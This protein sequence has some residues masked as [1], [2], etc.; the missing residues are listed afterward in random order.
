MHVWETPEEL[1]KLQSLLDASYDSGGPH[2]KDIIT[3]ERRLSAEEL[4]ERLQGM[5][6]L[7]VATVTANGRPLVGPVDSYFIHGSFF[8][9]SGR[10]SVKMRHLAAR[11]HVS[12]IYLPNEQ[13]SISVHGQVELFDVLDPTHAELREAM[14]AHYAPTQG[15]AFEEWMIEEDP[16]GARIDA[17]KI[18]TFH[19]S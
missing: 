4:C 18:F 16:L 12:A 17:S 5:C 6:L 3:P 11:P 15:P 13:L 14:L 9:S 7:A 1:L 2:L 10:Q 8:F 19:M